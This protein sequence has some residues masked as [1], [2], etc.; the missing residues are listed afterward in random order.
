MTESEFRFKHS[1]LIHFYQ[2]IEL[3][4]RAICARMSNENEKDWF[5]KYIELETDTFGV[6]IQNLQEIQRQRKN[7]VLTENDFDD[8]NSIRKTRNYWVHQC[9]NGTFEG[10]N[11]ISFHNGAVNMPSHAQKLLDSLDVAIEW[12]EKL[13]EI[14]YSLS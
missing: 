3:R 10:V 5:S 2:L 13:A 7:T 11:P 6:L 9:F 12:D 14:V 1:L 4:L 8:L